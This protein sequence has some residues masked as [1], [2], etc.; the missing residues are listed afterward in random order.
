MKKLI[1]VVFIRLRTEF[2]EHSGFRLRFT[3]DVVQN[4]IAQPRQARIFVTRKMVRAFR[5]TSRDG[6]YQHEF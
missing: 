5:Q 6:R 4:A 2:R 1:L 3:P